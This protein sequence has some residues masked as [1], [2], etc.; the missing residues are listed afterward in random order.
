MKLFIGILLLVFLAAGAGCSRLKLLLPS[1]SRWTP[2]AKEPIPIPQEQQDVL[3]YYTYLQGLT[4]ADLDGE[5]RVVKQRYASFPNDEDRWRLIFLSIQPGQSFSNREYALELLRGLQPEPGSDKASRKSLGEL[6]SLLLTDQRELK[7][8]LREEK[9]R[10]E[11][12]AQ[13]LQELKEIENILS[14]RE[15]NRPAA[16]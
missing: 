10:A 11:Q 9:Q 1:E 4:G 14:E 5:F 13:Q 7:R 2:A 12:L 8:N 3:A 16:K 6:L 15:K